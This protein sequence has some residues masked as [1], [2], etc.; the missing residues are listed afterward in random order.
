MHHWGLSGHPGRILWGPMPPVMHEPDF[1]KSPNVGTE[2]LDFASQGPKWEMGF[3]VGGGLASCPIWRGGS[4]SLASAYHAIG[5]AHIELAGLPE[6]DRN[7]I[8]LYNTTF[9]DSGRCAN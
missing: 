8:M 6:A 1:R 3:P 5:T 7:P 9:S 4:S 2:H